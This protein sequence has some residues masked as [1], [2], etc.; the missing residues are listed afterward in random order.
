MSMSS[1]LR[2]SLPAKDIYIYMCV[3]I[4]IYI[5]GDPYSE[6]VLSP[7]GLTSV[8]VLRVDDSAGYSL[9]PPTIP[10]CTK[11]RTHIYDYYR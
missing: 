10:A 3:Y 6:F 4:Y 2:Q 9:P 8:V 7:Q 5:Y 1:D 11:T